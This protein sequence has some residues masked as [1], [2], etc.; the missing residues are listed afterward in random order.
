MNTKEA[1]T[2]EITRVRVTR[3][4][5]DGNVIGYFV[6]E[7]VGGVLRVVEEVTYALD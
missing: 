4:D 2:A 1:V 5:A 3:K 7:D 6:L